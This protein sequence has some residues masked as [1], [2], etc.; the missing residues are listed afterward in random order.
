MK[1]PA[2]ANPRASAVRW[3]IE[4]RIHPFP[5]GRRVLA[6]LALALASAGLAPVRAEE[7]PLLYR[8]VA[9]RYGLS[10]E[11]LYALALRRSGRPSR[12]SSAPAPWPWTVTLCRGTRCATVHAADRATM[13]T[14]LTAGRRAG[15]TLYAGPLGLPLASVPGL[16]PRAATSPRVT[17]A[18][19]ARQWV[20]AGR[21]PAW[22][23]GPAA[24]GAG[25]AP[26]L[27][28]PL[29]RRW[30]PLVDRVAREEG[31]DPALV[32]AV[33]A[34]ESNYDPRAASPVGAVGLMQLMPATA[35]RF[36]LPR[37]RRAEPEPN[38]R[39]GIRYLQWLLA[40]FDRDLTLAVAG[41]NAGEGAVLQ[42]GRQVP[43]FRETQ[44]YVRRVA[45]R[46]ARSPALSIAATGDPR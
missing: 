7:P 46:M 5:R 28:T 37:D 29:A 1:F 21:A 45:Q 22:G 20:L 25:R 40:Y 42:Y 33:V 4:M 24:D 39:A 41:Y 14:V 19:A 9:A 44:T 3:G 13:A 17:L 15:L 8:Q 43:P 11:R 6:S 18:E 23:A 32:H 16:P 12:F 35:E 27:S 30:G 36:G 10:A 34:A 38:L 26:R 31:L 2:I